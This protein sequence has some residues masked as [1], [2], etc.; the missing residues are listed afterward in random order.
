[1]DYAEKLPYLYHPELVY[2][3][4]SKRWLAE[5]SLKSANDRVLD[6]EIDCPTHKTS[7]NLWYY[8]S[9]DCK[10][11]SVGVEAEVKR[12][13]DILKEEKVPYVLKLTQSLSSVG[14]MIPQ[15]EDERSKLVDRIG[16]YLE[17]YIPRITKENA[18]LY[19]TSLILSEFIKGDTAALNFYIKRDGTPVFLG[20]CHQLSTGESGRQATAITYA[21]QE[22]LEPKYRK[23]L[24]KVGQELSSNGYWGPVGADIMENPNDKTL[25]VID[26]NVRMPLS[27]VLYALRTHFTSRELGMSIAYECIMLTISRDELEKRFEKEFN[28]ARIV[29]LGATRVGKKEQWAYGM[30]VAG[31]GKKEIDE[32]TDRI[33]QFEAKTD[34]DQ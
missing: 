5:C 24:D 3:L 19:T 12:I 11:C 31:E 29:L 8:G 27:L 6:C 28:E 30:V 7:D 17:E 1:M 16:S 32:L 33:L 34:V 9:K 23:T 10:D 14:T 20:A 13:N 2:K 26:L 21:E 22:D 4:N 18:H 15:D 25:F